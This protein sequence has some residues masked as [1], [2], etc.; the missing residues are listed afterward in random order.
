M[1]DV[2]SIFL[3]NVGSGNSFA[4]NIRS[5]GTTTINMSNDGSN[6]IA[7][8]PEDG[9]T[10]LNQHFFF[11]DNAGSSNTLELTGSTG[12]DVAQFTS[13]NDVIEGMTGVEYVLD[14]GGNLEF[15]SALSSVTIATSGTGGNLTLDDDGNTITISQL[16]SLSDT[17]F[18][19]HTGSVTWTSV[20]GGSSVDTITVQGSNNTSTVVHL[21]G[22]GGNDSFTVHASGNDATVSNLDGGADTDTLTVRSSGST[23]IDATVNNISNV[24]NLI[25][26]K[27]SLGNVVV[28]LADTGVT[29]S[30]VS[31][32]FDTFTGGTSTDQITLADSGVTLSNISDVETINGGSSGDTITVTGST[33]TTVNAGA[34]NDSITGGQGSDQ[35]T[36]ATGADRFIFSGAAAGSLGTD[37]LVDF[38]GATQFGG[39]S[40]E[41]DVLVFDTSNLGISSIVYDEISWNGTALTGSVNNAN[42]TVVVLTGA[43]GS[44]TAA[45]AAVAGNFAGNTGNAIVIFNDSGNSTAD[46]LT[47]FHTTNLNGNGTENDIAVFSGVTNTSAGSNLTDS[48][49]AV[50]A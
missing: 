2:E 46:T 14:G 31:G 44:Q 13:G 7:G 32:T 29:I 41:S 45:A 39:G 9:S 49:F 25:G 10:A 3:P 4:L 43:S 5:A 15:K 12:D 19:G 33:A 23:G 11:S 26:T 34:G 42:A 48:D 28:S 22:G 27:D 21:N 18:N 35:L 20:S 6:L 17:D 47:A 36:G 38:S 30:S 16:S 40:G 8:T 24:E 37:T 1:Q 50:Q